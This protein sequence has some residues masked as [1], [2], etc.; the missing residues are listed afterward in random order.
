MKACQT[1]DHAKNVYQDLSSKINSFSSKDLNK[2]TIA[3]K[4]DLICQWL[5]KEMCKVWY[6]YPKYSWA[7]S[8]IKRSIFFD[9]IPNKMGNI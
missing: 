6:I 7:T 8:R 1:I 2:Q 4:V 5:V 9:Q 3:A